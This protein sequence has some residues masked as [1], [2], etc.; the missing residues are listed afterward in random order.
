ML[1]DLPNHSHN[2]PAE[3]HGQPTPWAILV[4]SHRHGACTN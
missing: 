2:A 4:P 1:D 3:K